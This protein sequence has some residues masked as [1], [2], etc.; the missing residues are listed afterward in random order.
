MSERNVFEMFSPPLLQALKDRGFDSPTGP[1]SKL[2]PL[3]REGKNALLMAPTGTGKTEAAILPILDAM[4]REGETRVKGTKLLYITPLRALN[5]DMLDRMQWWCKRFDIR[6]GVR[7]GDS[8]QAERTNMSVAPP[9]ILITTPETLQILLVG[10]RIRQNLSK[11]RWVVVDEVHEL[12]EDKRG[13]Q[14]SV[15][16]ERLR[17]AVEGEFQTVGLSATVGSPEKVAQF[18]VGAGR[19]CE[20]VRVPVEKSLSLKVAAPRPSGEDRIL[21]ESIFSFPEVAARLRTIRETVEKYRSVL[22]FTNTRTEAEALANRFRVWDPDLPIGVHHSSLSKATREAVERSLKEGKL[23][24]VICTSSLE[25]GID[26]GFLKYVIQYNS[27]RQ[28]TRLVQRV[29]RSGHSVGMVSSGMVMTQDSDDTLEAAVLCRRTTAGEI[30]PLEPVMAPYDVAIHQ[31]AGLLIEQS[32]WN[33]SDLESLFRRSY[34]YSGMEA[35]K[36][37]RVLAYMRERYPRLAYYSESDGKVFRA[38][39]TKPL[40]EYYFDNL[41]MIPDEKQY[42][43]MEGPSFVGTLDEAFVSEYG[44]VG[45][46]F[47]EAGRCWKIE[48]VYGN[49]VHVRAEDDP[50]GAVPTWVG[51][52]IP[53]PREV[54]AEV[55]M[56]RG[57]YAEEL[58]KGRG[59]LFIAG[60]AKT[61]PV[62]EATLKEALAEVAEQRAA[63]LPVPSDRL[64]TIEKWDRYV[65]IQAAFGHKI[66]RLLA[67]VLGHMISEDLGQSVAVHQ[68]PYRIII[69][70]DVSTAAVLSAIGALRGADLRAETGKAVERS[71]ILKRRLIHAGKK[72]GAIAKDADYGSVSISGIM[73]ALRDTPVYEEAMSMIFHDDFDLEGAA[74][75]LKGI[76]EGEIEVKLIEGAGLS[77]VARIGIEEISRR[78]EIVSPERLR[79]LLRQSTRARINDTFLVAVCTRCWNFLELK[80]V[81]DLEGLEACPVC[82]KSAVALSTDSYE[83]VFSVAMKARSR[84]E[85]KGK[86]ER[87]VDAMRKS[88]ELRK[89]YGHAVDMLMAGRGIRLGDAAI[90]ASRGRKEGVD[91]V[92]LIIEGE[93]EALRKRYFF[94]SS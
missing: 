77:P 90:L 15:A 10:R 22:I 79:A 86:K 48:Q 33:F 4:V 30:E 14:L 58:E 23:L 45:V 72:C 74:G 9:D 83:T 70:A 11:L 28:V 66:N 49:K 1:Q 68:D 6:L 92:E 54:A 25:L 32:S 81:G 65:V 37:Q 61:Y 17:D 41:S 87:Q 13:S 80:R 5:R 2:V 42:L 38:K 35:P 26:I 88:A 27:P 64:V 43:V 94:D 39:D 3:V 76:G 89:E 20:V 73:E 69:E 50:T 67:R 85:L 56:I 44:E 8:S 18:L 40:F 46:K 59:D 63:G 19:R 47:V 34:S 57:S 71:G 36:L 21:A 16:L 75:V 93:R 84:S 12:C 55:G 31:V 82:G 60:M 91:V 62:S 51:D 52:E 53:V 7:H 78:G 29:G 24:G